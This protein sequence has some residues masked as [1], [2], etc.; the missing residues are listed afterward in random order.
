[1]NKKIEKKLYCNYKKLFSFRKSALFRVEQSE[2][3]QGE[4]RCEI[5]VVILHLLLEIW[6][7]M[8]NQ[9]SSRVIKN[10]L[11]QCLISSP[12]E[13]KNFISLCFISSH[14]RVLFFFLFYS[15]IN[16]H[17]E[18]WVESF[19]EKYEKLFQGEFFCFFDVTLAIGPQSFEKNIGKIA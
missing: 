5:K 15:L 11:I 3:K 10:V 12:P 9:H 8:L 6:L 2:E 17:S 16:S 19:L 14:P 1:M 4:A 18:M 13:Y 7:G